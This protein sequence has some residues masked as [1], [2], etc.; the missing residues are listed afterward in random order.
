MI[1]SQDW[2][3]IVN[4]LRKRR[5]LVV[6]DVMLD[7]YISGSV[8]RS[9]PEAGV[10]VVG[11]S[12]RWTVPGG[13]ANAAAN[14][15]ALGGRAVL[16]GVVGKDRAA[17]ELARATQARGVDPLGFMSDPYRPT[18]VRSRILAD[19][20]LVARVDTESTAELPPGVAG[21]FTLW[22]MH[23][24]KK[25][26]AVL[27]SDCGKGVVSSLLTTGMIE[28]AKR[29]GIPLVVDPKGMDARRY[30]GAA[31]VKPN[32]QELANLTGRTVETHAEIAEACNRL[33]DVLP[34]TALLVTLGANG[35]TLFRAGMSHRHFPAE[36]PS[37]VCD[38]TGAGDTAGAALTLALAAGVPIEMAVEIANTAAGIVVG[39]TGMAVVGFAELRKGFPASEANELMNVR[40]ENS[41]VSGGGVAIVTR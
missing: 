18:T 16:H 21:Q 37:D 33:F 12:R 30:R 26:D 14:I 6:G 32:L 41:V 28:A 35:M 27:L 19:G 5:V 9:C 13:A 7:E 23:A 17:E 40:N 2:T 3:S 29:A 39:K 22:A 15:V 38:M 24:A 36:T 4:S 8:C 31:V 1:H 10:P 20:Q 25:S 34:G 11:A